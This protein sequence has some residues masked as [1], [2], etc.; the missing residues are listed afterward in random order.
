MILPHA[1][2]DLAKK[3]VITPT[4]LKVSLQPAPSKC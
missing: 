2:Q 3:S 1:S 4:L